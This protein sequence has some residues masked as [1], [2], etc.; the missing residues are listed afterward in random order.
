MCVVLLLSCVLCHLWLRCFVRCV[1]CCSLLVR[2]L[3]DGCGCLRVYGLSGIVCGAP[4]SF[5]CLV[6]WFWV[7]VV[8]SRS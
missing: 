8:V 1:V 4:P 2:V 7:L 3:C 5:V 6:C